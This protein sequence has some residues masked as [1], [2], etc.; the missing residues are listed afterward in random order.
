MNVFQEIFKTMN[1]SQF[2]DESKKNAF[3]EMLETIQ[4]DKANSESTYTYPLDL[5]D[6]HVVDDKRYIEAGHLYAETQETG[7]RSALRDASFKIFD[8]PNIRVGH[9]TTVLD[10]PN[11]SYLGDLDKAVEYIEANMNLK[12]VRIDVYHDVVSVSIPS[13]IRRPIDL[14]SLITSVY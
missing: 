10:Y 14:K 6:N 5:F 2:D 12:Y 3:E 7:I 11:V 13:I 1:L 8:Y 9:T 4:A